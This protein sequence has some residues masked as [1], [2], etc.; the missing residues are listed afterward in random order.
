MCASSIL[1]GGTSRY[2]A[3]RIS[4]KAFFV[5]VT[6]LVNFFQFQVN[7]LSISFHCLWKIFV[8]QH[9]PFFP[10]PILKPQ[11][12]TPCKTLPRLNH[13]WFPRCSSPYGLH[14]CFGESY[15]CFDFFHLQLYSFVNDVFQDAQGNIFPCITLK[16]FF[17]QGLSG[18][19]QG[20][21]FTI[22]GF[23]AESL[24]FCNEF[25]VSFMVRLPTLTLAISGL[26][27]VPWCL[28]F[29]H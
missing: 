14:N 28:Q 7:P 12:F 23:S 13:F 22:P 19:F 29:Q 21:A 10:M 17:L 4:L 24:N 20:K 5:L 15:P 18:L 2:K 16:P 6:H 9:N 27:P 26:Y 3:F 25:R 1:A 8:G 11:K